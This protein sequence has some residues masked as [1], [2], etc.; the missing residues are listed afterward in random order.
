MP[1]QSEDAVNVLA[2]LQ[3][4][5]IAAAESGKPTVLVLNLSL[6]ATNLIPEPYFLERYRNPLNHNFSI[7]LCS[8]LMLNVLVKLVETCAVLNLGLVD[9]TVCRPIYIYQ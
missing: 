2:N 7:A 6:H 5:N 9:H 4:V 3:P 8:N 1:N